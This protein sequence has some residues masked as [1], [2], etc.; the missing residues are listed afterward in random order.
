M[1]PLF[2]ELTGILQQ[3]RDLVAKM[4]TT[5]EQK[6]IA[7]RD[8]NLD[9]LNNTVQQLTKLTLDMAKLDPKREE[10]QVRLEQVLGLERGATLTQMLPQAPLE[11]QT[12]LKELQSEIKED[13]NK[14]REIN[15][16]NGVLTNRALQVNS[17]LLKIFN[18]GNSQ[19]YQPTGSVKQTAK[20]IEMLNKTV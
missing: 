19:T 16:I 18:P 3:Q 6:N 7:L 20:G 17:A 4:L 14:L 1:E 2:F 9:E 13:F 8:N 10:I 15:E 5:A 12:H 11:L